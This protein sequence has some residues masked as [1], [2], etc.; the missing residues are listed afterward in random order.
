MDMDHSNVRTSSLQPNY[1]DLIGLP[2]V[3]EINSHN[4]FLMHSGLTIQNIKGDILEFN[5]PDY[6][7]FVTV[8][9]VSNNS[10]ILRNYNI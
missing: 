7:S 4:N 1:I 6:Y 5:V 8:I 9:L 2:L 10:K 3:G